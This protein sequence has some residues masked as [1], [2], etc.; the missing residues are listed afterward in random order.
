MFGIVNTS[1]RLQASLDTG[2]RTR[3]ANG[4]G[5]VRYGIIDTTGLVI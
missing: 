5:D 2:T 1:L 3:A 4:V